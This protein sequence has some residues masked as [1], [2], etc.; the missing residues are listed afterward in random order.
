MNGQPAE[1][2][3]FEPTNLSSDL[4]VKSF[5][6]AF[7]SQDSYIQL[8][9]LSDTYYDSLK[10]S[11][12]DRKLPCQINSYL[13]ISRSPDRLW[14]GIGKKVS[15]SIHSL[16]Y[17]KE[18]GFL[19]ALVQMKNNFTCNRVPHIVI[20]KNQNISNALI[21]RVLDTEAS[22]QPRDPASLQELYTPVKIHGKIGVMQ[23]S[24]EEILEA[25][26]SYIDGI[27]IERTHKYVT[28]PE[29]SM[30]VEKPLLR[31]PVTNAKGDEDSMKISLEPRG[32]AGRAGHADI[33]TGEKYRGETVM[34]GPRGGK[35]IMKDNKKVYVPTGKGETSDVVYKI[36]ILSP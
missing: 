24:E 19:V 13:L 14:H 34:K 3:L 32:H 8:L 33:D 15:L 2:L 4:E 16:L 20:A 21:S 12:P 17:N 10:M 7:L 6:G 29:V 28:R 25:S 11:T 22:A 27:E 18:Y 5:N 23:G 31:K 1:R 26:T 36:N 30:T 35:Y 9:R